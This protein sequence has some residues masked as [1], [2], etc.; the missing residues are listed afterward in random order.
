MSKSPMYGIRNHHL[1]NEGAKGSKENPIGNDRQISHAWK[2]K[3]GPKMKI[4]SGCDC[5]GS[6]DEH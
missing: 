1:A 2:G 5:S 4:P 6:G 3:N